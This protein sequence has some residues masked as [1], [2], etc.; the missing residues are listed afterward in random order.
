M[1][2]EEDSKSKGTNIAMAQMKHGAEHFEGAPVCYHDDPAALF[3]RGGVS[4]A[5][6]PPTRPS[7]LWLNFLTALLTLVYLLR[8]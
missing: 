7:G 5:L 6:E 1:C 8:Y 3:P 2:D 4:G